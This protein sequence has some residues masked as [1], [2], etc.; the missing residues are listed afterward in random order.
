M[1]VALGVEGEKGRG[2]A[3]SFWGWMA[4]C[5][6]YYGSTICA[7]VLCGFLYLCCLDNKKYF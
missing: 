5:L 3:E 4:R 6:L 2:L 7:F 1:M